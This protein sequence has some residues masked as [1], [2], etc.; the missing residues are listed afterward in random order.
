[1]SFDARY[2]DDPVAS[3]S[4]GF[5]ELAKGMFQIWRFFSH[6]RR[7]LTD[8]ITIA[9]SCRGVI[10]TADSWLT[11]ANRQAEQVVANAMAMA[12]AEGDIDECDRREIAF[13]P[14]D[15]V[16]YALQ[17]GTADTFLDACREVSSG[18]KKGFMLSTAH[19]ATRDQQRDYPFKDRIADVLPWMRSAYEADEPEDDDRDRIGQV[20]S[21]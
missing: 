8:D 13:C 1:M 5:D 14:I 10:V 3:A 4:I 2:A 16:E 11:M 6:S 15:D 19:A 7:G 9:S 17:H 21:T 18:E 12:D 20:V